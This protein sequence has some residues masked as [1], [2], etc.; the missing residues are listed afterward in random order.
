[1]KVKPSCTMMHEQVLDDRIVHKIDFV[2]SFLEIGLLSPAALEAVSSVTHK[3]YGLSK[4]H[5]MLTSHFSYFHTLT[6]RPE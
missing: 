4:R 1:M 5:D 6:G 3:Q 2:G